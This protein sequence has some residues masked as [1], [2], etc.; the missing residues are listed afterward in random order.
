M[1]AS[2]DHCPTSSS[3]SASR[4]RKL[5][6]RQ[7]PGMTS[8]D[9]T[10]A[11]S[12]FATADSGS[13]YLATAEH[14]RYL[15]KGIIDALH[16]VGLVLVTSDPPADLPM[17]ATALREASAPRPVIDLPC[18]PDLNFAQ[19]FACGPEHPDP[20][21]PVAVGEDAGSSASSP[22]IYLLADADRLSDNQIEEFYE[23]VQGIPQRPHGFAAGVLLAHPGFLT[24]AENAASDLVD[25]GLAAHLRVQQLDRG[26]VETFIRRRLP[27]GEADNLFTPQRVMLIAV[28]SGGDPAAVNRAARRMLQ[29]ELDASAGGWRG[30][31]GRALR[32]YLGKP[33]G[34]PA[35][36][37]EDDR[38]PPPR[39]RPRR[40]A[41]SLRLPAGVFICLG[42]V[43]L[44]AG[45]A[46]Q[47]QNLG[48]FVG[49]VRDYI[50]PRNEQTDAR[51]G[52]DAVASPV[53]ALGSPSVNLAIA[54]PRAAPTDQLPQQPGADADRPGATYRFGPASDPASRPAADREPL[55]AVEIAALVARGDAFLVA[56]DIASA[57]LLFERAAESRDGRAA[58]RLAVT[59]DAAF[60]E[61][62]GIHGLPS[63]PERAAFWYRRARELGAGKPEPPP[64]S[65]GAADPSAPLSR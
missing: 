30:R 39:V 22:A 34:R 41:V 19:L 2:S 60:L 40:H 9:L 55:S 52:V 35:A 36:D 57:R 45:N 61:R 28:A 47:R 62:A 64:G 16:R 13:E 7:S 15:A 3:E 21:A 1:Y 50:L 11:L 26:E 5:N 43:W 65:P 31:F 20:S 56:R 58:L 63:D 18:G 48:A 37:G 17:L 59:Y 4:G 10:L 38:I 6:V 8:A 27:P 46:S 32:R 24:R 29:T 25:E 51:Y 49:L 23:A 12:A 33:S 54:P 53:D 42:T 14:Y 44:V